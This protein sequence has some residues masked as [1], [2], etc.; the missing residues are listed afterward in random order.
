LQ[1]D[2]FVGIKGKYVQKSAEGGLFVNF[3]SLRLRLTLLGKMNGS[4]LTDEMWIS[5]LMKIMR[6]LRITKVGDE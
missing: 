1:S 5:R 2:L 4:R 3:L 6:K